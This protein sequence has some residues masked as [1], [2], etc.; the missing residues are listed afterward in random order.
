MDNEK[1]L[2]KIEKLLQQ[3]REYIKTIVRTE[4]E[5]EAKRT[6]RDQNVQLMRLRMETS[7]HLREVDDRLK[8]IEIST[9]ATEMKVEVVNKRIDESIEEN[10]HFFQKAGEFFDEMRSE[11]SQR[12]EKIEKF[13]DF[14]TG[15]KN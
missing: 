14:P 8:N 11:L 7:S 10:A 1:L 13:L 4:T 15:S 2:E 3:E 12:I 6:R 5:A 9:N